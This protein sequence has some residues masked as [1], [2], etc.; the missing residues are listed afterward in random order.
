MKDSIEKGFV[1]IATG[2]EEYYQI[3]LNL[4][5]SYKAFCNNPLPFAIIADRENEYTKHFDK[6]ILLDCP[7]QSYAD[8]IELLNNIPFQETI[9]IESDCLA[10]SDLNLYFEVFKDADDFSAFGW[11]KPISEP[12]CGWF[13][14]EETGK[15]KDSIKLF[16]GI[17]SAVIFLRK[18]DVC[19]R[20]YQIC[21]DIWSHYDQYNIGNSMDMLDDKLFAVSSAVIPCRMT[22]HIIPDFEPFCVFPY[23]INNRR[24]PRPDIV[25]GEVT[26]IHDDR[27]KVRA[28]ICHWGSAYTRRVEYKKECAGLAVLENRSF[29]SLL[30]Y[31]SF[32]IKL[33]FALFFRKVL[34][35]F[36]KTLNLKF[37]KIP[38]KA[39][40]RIVKRK[41]TVSD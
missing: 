8:K 23:C 26:F 32:L 11:S 2:K 17:H 5:R 31:Y 20:M 3:A 14:L 39:L 41:R 38:A 22:P 24:H 29:K 19:A 18:T 16:Q 9:F 10:Y 15:Y 6:T 30:N 21:M 4:L 28:M 34:W 12:E 7:H 27:K 1:T 35:L 13:R 37:I 40:L 33:P 25:H 36:W